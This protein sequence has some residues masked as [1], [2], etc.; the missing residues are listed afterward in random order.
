MNPFTVTIV[1]ATKNLLTRQN[2]PMLKLCHRRLM[3][4]MQAVSAG[5]AVHL[6]VLLQRALG[7][8][9]TG[10]GF[11]EIL[12]ESGLC[13]S[14]SIEKVMTGK[15]Y[16]RAMRVHQRMLEALERMLLEAFGNVHRTPD[17]EFFSCKLRENLAVNPSYANLSVNI[18]AAE[19]IDFAEN[20]NNFKQDVRQGK[21]GKTAQLWLSY[22]DCV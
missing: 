14:G 19:F 18:E 5:L 16:N 1:G 8:M 11:E 22:S 9:M 15:H 20:Y 2:A 7:K 3:N 10:S 13:A 17:D 21:L 4:R 12:I 6:A